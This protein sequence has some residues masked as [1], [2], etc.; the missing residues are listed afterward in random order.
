MCGILAV[1][2]EFLKAVDTSSLSLRGRDF[3]SSE[4]QGDITLC[5]FL[6]NTVGNVSQ[7]LK[8]KGLF[9]CNCEI[10]NYR[11]LCEKRKFSCNNDSEYLFRLLES[12][13]SEDIISCSPEFIDAVNELEGQYSIVYS[14]DNYVIAFRDFLGR[15]PL[16][17]SKS[18]FMI[19][20]TRQAFIDSR[21]ESSYEI[22][23]R[24][25]LIYDVIKDDISFNYMPVIF[26]VT[27][28]SFSDELKDSA[29]EIY[30]HANESS[31]VGMLFSGGV[32][33]LLIAANLKN[34]G[35]DIR[36]YHVT[37]KKSKDYENALNAANELGLK[38][39]E[40]EYTDEDIEEA[41]VQ[42][43]IAISEPHALKVSSA[44]TT[45]LAS[46]K[47]REDGC[48]VLISG[49]GA[50]EILLGYD[51]ERKNYDSI[52][53]SFSQLLMMWERNCYKEDAIAMHNGIEMRYP[54][55][56]R[57]VITSAWKAIN[58]PISGDAK[59]FDTK[60]PI[61]DSLAKLGVSSGLIRREKVAAQYGS[62]TDK[63]F[64]RIAR[65]NKMT[66]SAYLKKK[67]G[68]TGKNISAL[69]STGKDSLYSVYLL[70][71]FNYNI[72]NFITINSEN[73]DSFMYHTP[74]VALAESIA[75]LCGKPLISEDT[76]GEKE[77]ELSGLR[78]AI[79]DSVE[80]YKVQGISS[81]AIRSNYQRNRLLLLC[82]EFGLS[83]HSPLWQCSEEAYAKSLLKFG[84]E[85]MIVRASAE[86]LG[87]NDVGRLYDSD[88]IDNLKKMNLSL[89][90]EGG[91]F[92]TLVLNCP[93]YS[94][95]LSLPKYHIEDRDEDYYMVLD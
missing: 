77:S 81:G 10:Y 56:S 28:R 36:L 20:S 62:G 86:G 65:K 16:C 6:H 61:R 46:K 67:S 31:M 22:H 76:A 82:E 23:P 48:K 19:A 74:A 71:N 85:I 69:V 42:C 40:V 93:L 91:E 55:L 8:G 72:S 63:S 80:N 26:P 13:S 41:A 68:L 25:M 64:E 29:N 38:I 57:R 79:H 3:D 95:R 14:R 32:D 88:F 35:R 73:P 2:D 9:S 21:I 15:T 58:T 66:K 87:A 11:E 7:P 89:V 37:D 94:E 51:R 70:E 4:S 47:A 50:D 24:K 1:K 84:F 59:N 60:L 90:G 92:E 75:K 27:A 78:R 83:L 44:L 39:T 33:S 43:A 52:S 45:H 18:P 54:Y 5:H 30:D 49:F 12:F 53:E 34:S 17:Y